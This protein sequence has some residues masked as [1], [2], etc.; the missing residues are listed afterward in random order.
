MVS[1]ELRCPRNSG[2]WVLIGQ[3]PQRLTASR[4]GALGGMALSSRKRFGQNGLQLTEYVYY[5][6]L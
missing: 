3:S 4:V 2:T 5:I 6:T 1:P